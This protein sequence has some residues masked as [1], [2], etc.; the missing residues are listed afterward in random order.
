MSARRLGRRKQQRECTVHMWLRH[1]RRAEMQVRAIEFRQAPSARA[2]AYARATFDPT[3]Q[4]VAYLELFS[5]LVPAP[6]P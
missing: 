2:Q 5:K 3:R 1:Q 4:V 6:A